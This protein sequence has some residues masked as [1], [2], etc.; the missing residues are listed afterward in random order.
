M[1]HYV[2][3]RRIVDGHFVNCT[4]TLK[5]VTETELSPSKN[6][7]REAEQRG[8]GATKANGAKV[9]HLGP[10]INIPFRRKTWAAVVPITQPQREKVNKRNLR[11][12]AKKREEK[13]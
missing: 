6:I 2:K 4:I 9:G 8:N 10:Q 5:L 1:A 11:K 13:L 3:A 12:T 7:V